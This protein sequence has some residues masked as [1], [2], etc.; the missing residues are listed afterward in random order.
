MKLWYKADLLQYPLFTKHW[1]GITPNIM[2]NF[3]HAKVLHLSQK[4]QESLNTSNLSSNVSDVIRSAT[5]Q[6]ET[7]SFFGVLQKKQTQTLQEKNAH[8]PTIAII[9]ININMFENLQHH[10]TIIPLPSTD[11]NTSIQHSGGHYITNLNNACFS[12]EIPQNHHLH[13]LI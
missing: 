4:F 12:R 7:R 6:G 3:K 1:L 11:T 2:K 5:S 9:I 8:H 13:C 10:P